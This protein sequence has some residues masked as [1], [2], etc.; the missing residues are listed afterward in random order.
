MAGEITHYFAGGNTAKGFYN[1]FESNM[2]GME[3]IYLIKGGPGTGKSTMMKKIAKVWNE[4]GFDIEELHCSSDP[5][6]LDGIIIP[7]LKF[8]VFDATAPHV[9]EPKAPGAIENYINL[10]DAW[11]SN[12]LRESKEKIVDIQT[13]LSTYYSKAYDLFEKGLWIHDE[14][15]EIYINE[16]DFE[17]ANKLTEKLI[18]LIFTGQKSEVGEGITRHRFFG[19]STPKGVMDFIPNITEGLNKRF[20]IK[21]RAGTGKSTMLKKLAQEAEDRHFDVELY[22]CGFDPESMDMVLI[23]ELGVCVFDST[24]PHEYFPS[25]HGDEIVDVYEKAVTPGTDEKYGEEIAYFNQRYKQKMKEGMEHLKTAKVLHDQLEDIYI[26]AVDFSLVDQYF[27][28]LNQKIKEL[29]E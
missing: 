16:M 12:L 17:K 23:R 6:S 13:E 8:G 4:K 24:D 10:G 9:L 27:E 2:Q 29:Q 3:H 15:E 28:K 25:R 1:L 19:A 18:D 21:G 5:D 11:D 20:F 22:H 14:L 7:S 26:K